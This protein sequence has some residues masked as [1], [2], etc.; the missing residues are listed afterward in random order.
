MKSL[1]MPTFAILVTNIFAAVAAVATVTSEEE[2]LAKLKK[3]D[4]EMQ[5]EINAEYCQ[6]ECGSFEGANLQC[7]CLVLDNICMR[8][9]KVPGSKDPNIFPEMQRS[10]KELQI[11]QQL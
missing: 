2:N 5:A 9:C 7:V 3:F 11:T 4:C 10:I 6:R 8:G 1:L